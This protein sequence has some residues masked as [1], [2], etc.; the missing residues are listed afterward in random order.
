MSRKVICLAALFVAC[1]RS[2]ISNMDAVVP[3]ALDP[4]THP[5]VPGVH[6]CCGNPGE[7]QSSN[8]V[9]RSLIDDNLAHCVQ[10]GSGFDAK[11]SS[12]GLFC[13][14]GLTRIE[15]YFPVEAGAPD[16]A[17]PPGCG[18]GPPSGKL[19]SKC[20]DGVCGAPTENRC[21]CAADCPR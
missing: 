10:E 15:D 20:G 3:D 7:I 21:N 4:C 1:S 8:C 6:I 5:A 2:G 9:P 12:L 19:C 17:L 14:A 13:C 16:P 11:N 18:S